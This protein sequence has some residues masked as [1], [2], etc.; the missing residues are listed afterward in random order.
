MGHPLLALNDGRD[1]LPEIV[2]NW[3]VGQKIYDIVDALPEFI[4]KV[5]KLE[6]LSF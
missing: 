6:E 4:E 1:L 2:P 5:L 3:R